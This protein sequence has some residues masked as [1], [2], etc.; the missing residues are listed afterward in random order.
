MDSLSLSVHWHKVDAYSNYKCNND[1]DTLSKLRLS[2]YVSLSDNIPGCL[3]SIVATFTFS[4]Y[5]VDD[6]II[7]LFNTYID[8]NTFCEFLALQHFTFLRPI[9]QFIN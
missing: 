5:T 2:N 6:D 8:I 4:G 3:L 1:V 7:R 9:F